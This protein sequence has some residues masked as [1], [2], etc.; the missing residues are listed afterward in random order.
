[1]STIDIEPV[2]AEFHRHAA[3][4]EEVASAMNEIRSSSRLLNELAEQTDGASNEALDRMAASLERVTELTDSA[5]HLEELVERFASIV[6]VIEKIRG[7]SLSIDSLASQSHILSLNAS[8][9]AA[10]AGEQGRG[11]AVVATE[12]RDLAEQSRRAAKEIDRAVGEAGELVGD[13]QQLTVQAMSSHDKTVTAVDRSVREVEESMGD[14]RS[15]A[16]R[17]KEMLLEQ[18]SRVEACATSVQLDSERN[19]GRVAK[20]VGDITG[21]R[22]AD[23]DPADAHR[24]C[25]EMRVVDVRREDE[26]WGDLSHIEGAELHTITDS[27]AEVVNDWSRDEPVLFVCHRGG[28]SARAASI[29]LER[30]FRQVYNLEGGMLAW[31]EAKLPVAS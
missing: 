16:G 2:V 20:L 22:V 25:R 19:A 28:R 14:I 30:G 8:I 10:R 26:F 29:A 5:R 27:F 31:H 12:V 1:M 3:L 7:H 17:M 18:S 13:V 15:L 4:V 6:S 23:I 9:E 24:R 21:A 11:F